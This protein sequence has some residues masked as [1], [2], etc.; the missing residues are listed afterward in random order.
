MFATG[1][2]SR[3]CPVSVLSTGLFPALERPKLNIKKCGNEQARIYAFFVFPCCLK[4]STSK[5]RIVKI[6]LQVNMDDKQVSSFLYLLCR[7]LVKVV[8]F[9]LGTDYVPVA[10]NWHP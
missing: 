5:T 1:F 8:W 10:L 7:K 2:R 3:Y 9:L 6:Y 4:H